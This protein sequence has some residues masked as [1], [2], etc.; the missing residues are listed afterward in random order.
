MDTKL[1]VGNFSQQVTA[2]ALR[3]LF[4]RHGKVLSVE[5]IKDP[6]TGQSK[7]FAFI[8]MRSPGEAEK[9]LSMYDGYSLDQRPLKVRLVERAHKHPY[10]KPKPRQPALSS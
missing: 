6:T 9:V 1:Y 7:G 5:L 3:G 4:S 2:K 8:E 10:R